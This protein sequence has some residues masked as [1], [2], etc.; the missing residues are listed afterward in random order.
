MSAEALAPAAPAGRGRVLWGLTVASAL[1]LWLAFP[2]A[3]IGAF[4]WL[5]LIP[6][7]LALSQLPPVR[8]LVHGLAFGVL[9]MGSICW[10]VNTLGALPWV[11]LTLGMAAYYAVFGLVASLIC[12]QAPAAAR[13]PALAA[14][15]TLLEIIRGSAGPIAFTLG[16][17]AYSQHA[18]LPIA[19]FA[20]LTGHYGVTFLVALLNAGLATVLLGMLPR[21]WR[22]PGH[23][24]LFNRL[25][26]RMALVCYLAVFAVYLWGSLVMR[27]GQGLERQRGQ[28]GPTLPVAVVQAVLPIAQQVTRDQIAASVRA[29]DELSKLSPPAKL[30]VW[31]ETAVPSVIT[32]DPR[33]QQRVKDVAYREQADLLFGAIEADGAAIHNAAFLARPNGD[34]TSAYRKC[35]LVIFGEY[36]PFRDQWKFLQRY[37]IR[38]Q[39]FT[40]GSERRLVPVDHWQVAPLICYEGIFPEPAREVARLGADVIALITSDLWAA[41]TTE[42]AHHSLTG[43]FRA[44]ETRRYLIRAASNGVS[45]V[46]DPYGEAMDDLPLGIPGVA[47]AAI[48]TVNRQTTSYARYGNAPLILICVTFLVVGLLTRAPLPQPAEGQ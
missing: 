32:N 39:D 22:R 13:V 45:A 10:F 30:I 46:Y 33:N 18:Q 47:R 2:P 23:P 48:P 37:P 27:V 43:P 41:G 25:A 17:L 12:Q 42:P 3:A 21:S 38:M 6:L 4:A 28:T 7:V 26:G 36:V 15:W 35:D 11:A 19:Q 20:S 31:P 8:G 5:G 24:L 16:D 29:Y 44:I 1:L 14:A 40:P 34:L 9:F